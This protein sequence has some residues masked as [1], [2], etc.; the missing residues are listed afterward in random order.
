MPKSSCI[1]P[2]AWHLQ[3]APEEPYCWQEGCFQCKCTQFCFV[4]EEGAV[5][6]G[7]GCCYSR[8]PEDC[9]PLRS[10]CRSNP[11]GNLQDETTDQE[12]EALGKNA[13]TTSCP[14]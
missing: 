12:E 4:G 13:R 2:A 14:G 7:L 6:D 8:P 11:D 10:L 3:A 5:F 1:P 9:T